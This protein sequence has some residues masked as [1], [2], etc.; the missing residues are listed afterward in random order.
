MNAAQRI[1]Q[2]HRYT[3]ERVWR[4]EQSG[5]DL[6]LERL[7]WHDILVGEVYPSTKNPG[8]WHWV[9]WVGTSNGG[10]CV[11]YANARAALWR[12]LGNFPAS[13]VE[14]MQT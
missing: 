7:Y 12:F 8:R 9:C 2:P 10:L 4:T 3:G 14:A 13:E 11:T 1:R 5:V 6:G